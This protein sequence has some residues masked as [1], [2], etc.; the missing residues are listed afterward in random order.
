MQQQDKAENDLLLEFYAF[1]TG[2]SSV[3]TQGDVLKQKT[4]KEALTPGKGSR[5]GCLELFQNQKY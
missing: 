2:L 1:L 3:F 5:D 4:A